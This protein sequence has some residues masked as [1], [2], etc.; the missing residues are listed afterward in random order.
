MTK[1]FEHMNY[2][3]DKTESLI[4]REKRKNLSVCWITTKTW[5][6]FYMKHQHLASGMIRAATHQ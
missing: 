6:G 1:I 3:R 4:S 2:Y 5:T